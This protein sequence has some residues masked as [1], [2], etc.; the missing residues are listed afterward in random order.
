VRNKRKLQTLKCL[1]SLSTHKTT[2]CDSKGC[3]II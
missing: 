1:W 2:K 3:L